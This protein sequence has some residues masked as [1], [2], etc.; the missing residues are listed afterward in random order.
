MQVTP[1]GNIAPTGAPALKQLNATPVLNNPQT[2][3]ATILTSRAV[4]GVAQ[5]FA[6]QLQLA[7]NQEILQFISNL[8]LNEGQQVTLKPT[9]EGNFQ[10]TQVL[11]P[12]IENVV[13]QVL[14]QLLPQTQTGSF[15]QLLSSL[16]LV[17]AEPPHLLPQAAHYAAEQLL[18]QI[19]KVDATEA[20]EAIRQ[21]VERQISPMEAQ[22]AHGEPISHLQS[23]PEVLVN[24]IVESLTKE[25]PEKSTQTRPPTLPEQETTAAQ[26]LTYSPR[27]MAQTPIPERQP[28]AASSLSALI[29]L[30]RPLVAAQTEGETPPS[31]DTSEMAPL[32]DQPTEHSPL[33]TSNKPIGNQQ[34]D[35]LADHRAAVIP[36]RVHLFQRLREQALAVLA[37]SQIEKTLG[38]YEQKTQ[39]PLPNH[40]HSLPTDNQN[41]LLLT[42]LPVQFGNHIDEV[43]LQI[44][45]REAGSA[46]VAERQEW[47]WVIS[48]G[49]DI[50]GLGEMVVRGELSKR[51]ISADLWA[52][53]D[54][55]FMLM[56]NQLPWLTGRLSTLGLTVDRMQPHQGLPN[57][58]EKTPIQLSLV[59]INA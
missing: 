15:A 36:E 37:N 48:L 45:Q 43:K 26:P 29:S 41:I 21:W 3:V 54:K 33:A 40:L 52:A 47:Q 30:L 19:P 18:T 22:L 25:I 6:G 49:F 50:E 57:S 53:K 35:P 56:Q 44:G 9:G 31:A 51:H 39:Q 58:A 14:R 59:D 5:S 27:T 2:L 7:L 8:T 28:L 12:Q 13:E 4:P 16:K 32:P 24:R 42:T 38:A 55:T 11:P 46:S 10:I 1:S 20:T 23:R 34:N 17:T